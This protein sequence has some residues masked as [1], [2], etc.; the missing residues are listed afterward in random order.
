MCVSFFTT[1]QELICDLK[2]IHEFLLEVR[3]HA[4]VMV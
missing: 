2:V 4:E 3:S 1:L